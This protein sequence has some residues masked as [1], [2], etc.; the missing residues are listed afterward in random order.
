MV[1][2][3]QVSV[4]FLT[5]SSFTMAAPAQDI[6]VRSSAPVESS[7]Q[8]VARDTQTLFARDAE[9][10][11]RSEDLEAPQWQAA[12]KMLRF[13]PEPHPDTSN[14]NKRSAIDIE[15]RS[16]S[17]PMDLERRISKAL[18]NSNEKAKHAFQKIGG[19]IAGIASVI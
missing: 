4:L 10:T 1:Q 3:L 2:L 9:L 12:L 18:H 6:A 19:V 7:M 11:V 16:E 15:S 14:K 13:I 8:L 5:L 17:E